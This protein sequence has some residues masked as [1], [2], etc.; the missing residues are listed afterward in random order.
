MK[1]HE[2]TKGEGTEHGFFGTRRTPH[3]PTVLLPAQSEAAS[4]SSGHNYTEF[5][6]A[7]A[8][9]RCP[10]SPPRQQEEVYSQSCAGACGKE[11][12]SV[13]AE[14][15]RTPGQ[16]ARRSH[17]CAEARRAV[18]DTLRASHVEAVCAESTRFSSTR[19]SVSAG[20]TALTVGYNSTA[21]AVLV[22]T[23]H[24]QNVRSEGSISQLWGIPLECHHFSAVSRTC[25]SRG[26]CEKASSYLNLYEPCFGVRCESPL[27]VFDHLQ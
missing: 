1:T 6:A 7:Q 8:R 16:T 26:A 10:L 9:L 18:S 13:A 2:D 19:G 15:P 20:S 3:T 11:L 27:L 17:L 12:P 21:Y 24:S 5:L 4:S 23:R 14:V 25:Y 22:P